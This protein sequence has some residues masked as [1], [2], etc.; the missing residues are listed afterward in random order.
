MSNRIA[1][2]KR[3]SSTLRAGLCLMWRGGLCLHLQAI[4]PGEDP[5]MP[6]IRIRVENIE[7]LYEE[8]N[9]RGLI[10]PNGH[11]ES[12]PWGSKD[13]GLHDPGGAALV[14]YEDL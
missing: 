6:L 10:S 2:L 3:C 4:A 1:V 12:K 13:F 14:S 7:P 11:L 8:Y 9:A 5:T